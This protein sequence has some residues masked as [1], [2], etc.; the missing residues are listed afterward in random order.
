MISDSL[1]HDQHNFRL[2][3]NFSKNLFYIT[4]AAIME[5]TKLP[6]TICGKITQYVKDSS[7]FKRSEV[8]L[9]FELKTCQ[10]FFNIPNPPTSRIFDWHNTPPSYFIDESGQQYTSTYIPPSLTLRKFKQFVDSYLSIADITLRIQGV[11]MGTK[12][13]YAIEKPTWIT[14]SHPFLPFF[15]ESFQKKLESTSQKTYPAFAKNPN[16]EGI[17]FEIEFDDHPTKPLEI[18]FSIIMQ[19][20]LASRPCHLYLYLENSIYHNFFGIN[21]DREI[22]LEEDNIDSIKLIFFKTIR[23][24]EVFNILSTEEPTVKKLTETP[25]SQITNNS[26]QIKSDLNHYNRL[27]YNCHMKT[28]N[29]KQIEEQ[30]S[31][32]QVNVK[33][34]KTPISEITSNYST[35]S[36]VNSS[37]T[38]SPVLEVILSHIDRNM[39]SSVS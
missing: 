13:D 23:P 27:L 2:L 29:K 1:L 7:I 38:K 5:G 30:A 9:I 39:K 19:N 11:I 31:E 36:H 16:Q 10:L 20:F 21:I 4:K 15:P 34:N 28:Y 24:I 33:N 12:G 26:K 35:L 14:L 17:G 6:H 8:G 22:R 25:L 18:V 3:D 32:E 37:F